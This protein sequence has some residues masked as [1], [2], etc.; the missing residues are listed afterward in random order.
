M[1]Y[2][3]ISGSYIRLHK[4][5]KRFKPENIIA[6]HT[7]SVTV[8]DQTL[9]LRRA[10]RIRTNYE[11][12]TIRLEGHVSELDQDGPRVT[13]RRVFYKAE[14]P[15]DESPANPPSELTV[16]Q[17]LE[18]GKGLLLT[19]AAGTGKTYSLVNEII[20]ALEGG[21]LITSNTNK[22]LENLM[23]RG[24]ESTKV[25]T[26]SSL[27]YGN[28]N[29]LKHVRT[30]I[31]DEYTMTSQT[32]MT[33]IYKLFLRG[34]R[35]ILVGDFRQIP[36]INNK[37][38]DYIAFDFVRQMCPYRVDLKQVHRYDEA[39]SKT[40]LRV[41]VEGEFHCS[42]VK[43]RTWINICYTRRTVGRIN[44][45]FSKKNSEKLEET[46]GPSITINGMCCVVG[47]PVVC[48]K[49]LDKRL[50]NSQMY[51]I[52]AIDD[53]NETVTLIDQNDNT[54]TFPFR[55]IKAHFNMGHA[56][57]AHRLQGS[58]LEGVVCIHD[59]EKMSRE[60]LYTA[61]TR[62]TSLDNLRV[63]EEVTLL[64][65]RS[66][67]FVY[68]WHPD[69]ESLSTYR[70]YVY[71]MFGEDGKCFYIGM[72]NNL[73]KRESEHR[74]GNGT[75]KLTQSDEF[76]RAWEMRVIDETTDERELPKLEGKAIKG[77]V[78]AGG[79]LY[80][81]QLMEP[82]KK[83]KKLKNGRYN[84]RVV[85]VRGTILEKVDAYVYRWSVYGKRSEKRFGVT[86]KRDKAGALAAAKAFQ[87]EHYT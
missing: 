4:L 69:C 72:T 20:P 11:L 23:S 44:R 81:Q 28:T 54:N 36:S 83:R 57:T 58:T 27:F 60:I 42:N 33:Q 73:R 79:A 2:S 7:D 87:L 40:S 31:V 85:Q 37:L 86:K 84:K 10:N 16:K 8:C 68:S 51:D 13:R 47:T 9:N 50:T 45:K 49:K 48:T 63:P 22:S 77:Y 26:L 17:A 25:R 39:L 53:V 46:Q 62:L 61:L 34:M 55:V 30:L 59:I 52:E 78:A 65:I 6:F 3:I 80:N 19:G 35:I 56:L 5:S 14:T 70:G 18:T 66:E 24:V 1:F 29:Y 67:N 43:K 82:P 75:E 15:Y 12:G 21:S 74:S 41:Y 32:H 71:G 64:A 38:L 76:K